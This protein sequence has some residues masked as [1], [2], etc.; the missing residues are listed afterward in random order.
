MGQGLHH[1][2]HGDRHPHHQVDH[3]HSVGPPCLCSGRAR[4]QPVQQGREGKIIFI[5]QHQTRTLC[6]FFFFFFFF[7]FWG[8][9]NQS[10]INLN[11][12]QKY[13]SFL[14]EKDHSSFG[15]CPNI[16]IMFQLTIKTSKSA[17]VHYCTLS[18]SD[19][20]PARYQ[21]SAG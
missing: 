9:Q 12:K 7:F 15:E 16:L 19:I 17:L 13:G 1:H 2:H 11:I 5:N 4:V 10:V 3:L 8:S 14:W 20:W 6:L 21:I 18:L